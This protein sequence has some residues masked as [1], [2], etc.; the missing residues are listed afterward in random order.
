MINLSKVIQTLQIPCKMRNKH[1]LQVLLEATKNNQ[2]FKKLREE[3]LDDKIHQLCCKVMTLEKCNKG[4]VVFDFGDSGDKFYII[5]KGKVSVM[6]PSKK[7][8]VV[9]ASEI[10]KLKRQEKQR[11]NRKQPSLESEEESSESE[12]EIFYTQPTRQRRKGTVLSSEITKVL[13]SYRE[14][15]KT[16]EENEEDYEKKVSGLFENELDKERRQILELAKQFEG[17]EEFEIELEQ[18]NEVAGLGEGGSFG[19]FAL[20]NEKPRA[21]TIKAKENCFFAVLCK[22]D[23]KRILGNISQK[24][25]R[26]KI[27]FFYSLP[28][29]GGWTRIAL[30]KLSY[31]FKSKIVKK[32]QVLYREGDPVE[33]VYFVKEGEFRVSG[34]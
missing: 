13:N 14:T 18:L 34:N 3:E 7:S 16:Q 15:N 8:I 28:F 29:F 31:Y 17:E 25:L 12:E 2:F 10:K 22:S 20:L 21:A 23:F 1:D 26:D 32:N 30:T 5:L 33:Y 27:E 4:Q 6:I 24:R 11:M 9:N 19:E